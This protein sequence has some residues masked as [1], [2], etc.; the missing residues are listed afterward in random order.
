[1]NI[2]DIL[3]VDRVIC[4]TRINSKKRLLEVLSELLAAGGT[5]YLQAEIFESLLARERLGST[6][7]GNGVAIPHGR[8]R[9][10]SHAVGAFLRLDEPVDYDAIDGKPVDLV[11]AM[12]VPEESTEEHL[13]ALSALAEKFSNDKFCASLRACRDCEKLHALLTRPQES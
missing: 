9:S 4:H 10:A 2:S 11:F 5:P 1:M 6:G 13:Q 3:N 7:F 8:V 12:I